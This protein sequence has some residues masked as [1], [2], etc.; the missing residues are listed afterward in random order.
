MVP[1]KKHLLV[2]DQVVRDLMWQCCHFSDRRGP[3]NIL[4]SNQGGRTRTLIRESECTDGR[5]QEF[6]ENSS[7]CSLHTS[8]FFWVISHF[9]SGGG[10]MNYE[11]DLNITKRFLFFLT[12]ESLIHYK[13][14]ARASTMTM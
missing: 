9:Q 4:I 12:A 10:R 6:S 2:L 5:L 11:S 1:N 7:S 8:L 3:N 13:R 14:H